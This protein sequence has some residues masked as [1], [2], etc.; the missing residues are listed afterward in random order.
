MALSKNLTISQIAEKANVSIA[1]TSRVINQSGAVKPETRERVLQAMKDLNYQ[2]KGSRNENKFILTSFPDFDNPFNAEII[3]GIQAAARRRG[4]R[5]FL[6]QMEDFRSS[7]SYRFLLNQQ[8]FGGIIFAHLVPDKSLLDSLCLQH[9]V[10]MCSEH[11]D[12]DAVPFVAIDDFTAAYDAL[13]YLI[14]IGKKRI[15]ML[16]SSLDDYNYALHRERGYRAALQ[17]AGLPINEN[18]IAH[19]P[20]I[21]AE[22]ACS[23]AVSILSSADRP[24]AFFCVSDMFASAVIKAA[25]SLNLSIPDDV[26]IL[27]FDNIYLTTMTVPSITTVSQ[28]TYQIGYQSGN[29]LMDLME[30]KPVLNRRVIL[31][32]ELIVR[33]ST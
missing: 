17:K 19:L 28:P 3:N 13:D 29:L 18:W 2:Y 27:G 15:A 21:D 7:D 24:D 33:G 31:D 5:L 23:T 4:Y 11:S 14:S 10:V 16:N 20:A 12:T 22:F 32:T 26:A 1:T 8:V 9:P 25:R 6:Q 30:G